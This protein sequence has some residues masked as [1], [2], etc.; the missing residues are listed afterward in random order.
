MV[1]AMILSSVFVLMPVAAAETTVRI[2]PVD[3]EI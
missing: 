2:D 1:L 3:T